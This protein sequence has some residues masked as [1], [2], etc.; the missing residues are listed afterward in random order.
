VKRVLTYGAETAEALNRPYIGSEHLLLGLLKE[1]DCPATSMLEK[2]GITCERVFREIGVQDSI[3][4]DPPRLQPTREALNSLVATLPEGAIE[5]AY[6]AL[7]R[8]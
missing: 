3:A 8:L 5:Q 4:I 7:E 2:H 1:R 6:G